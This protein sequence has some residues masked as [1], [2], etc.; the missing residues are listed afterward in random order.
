MTPE[1]AFRRRL[2]SLN[3]EPLPNEV[4]AVAFDRRTLPE[5]RRRRR[6]LAPV[7]SRP[8][9][10]VKPIPGLLRQGEVV[11]NAAGEHVCIRI[12]LEKLW[13]GGEH[14]VTQRHRACAA[15]AAHEVGNDVDKRNGD[16]NLAS[17]VEAYPHEVVLL[18]LETCGLAG[19]A[20]FLVGLLRSIDQRP[21]VE[22]LLARNYAEERAVL[23]S[24]WQ[25]IRASTV[26]ATFNGKSFDWPMVLDRSTRHLLFRNSRPPEPYH[27]DLLHAA[28]RR[29]KN[30]LPDCRL[31]TI[32]Q[33]VCGRRR[34]DVIPGAQIPAAYQQFVRTGFEREMESI[35]L[36]NAVDLV[37]LL[38]IAMRLAGP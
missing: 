5:R 10:V 31:Q 17:F 15:E 12:D 30:Q 26:L 23:A 1:E 16:A 37:T 8:T 35:L 18:D 4:D 13:P 25:R 11:A 32:E 21:T 33:L 36:H 3:R 7:P 28:R 19:S 2:E 34:G 24:L 27:V 22:L 9:H 29:W 38:D 20:L 14:L 6:A